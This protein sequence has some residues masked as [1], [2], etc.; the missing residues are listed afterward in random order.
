M[1]N[2]WKKHGFEIVTI[3][4]VIF[5]IVVALYQWLFGKNRS[6]TYS[7]HYFYTK[8]IPSV[9]S[10]GKQSS[11]PFYIPK[12]SKGEV[13][14]RQ[15]LE[16]Y[17]NKPFDKIRPDFLKN[18]VTGGDYNLELDC[19]NDELKLALEYNGIQHYKYIPYFHRNKEAFLNQKYRDEMKRVKCKENGVILIEVPYTVKENEIESYVHSELKSLGF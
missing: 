6:G 7:S 14:C 16:S 15:V 5:I 8:N 9:N 3:A 11:S 18:P 1:I 10:S 2:F 17:F 4:S 13:K 12:E 19:Y